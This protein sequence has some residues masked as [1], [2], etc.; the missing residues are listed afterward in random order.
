MP[1]LELMAQISRPFQIVLVALLALAMLIVAWFM[2]LHRSSGT[3]SSGTSSPSVSASAGGSANHA[4]THASSAGGGSGRIYHG[5]APGVEGLTRDIKR[6]HEAAAQE[7]RGGSYDEKHA[8]QTPAATASAG[9]PA[10]AASHA[11][12]G[13]HSASTH[14][15]AAATV[16]AHPG[17]SVSHSRASATTGSHAPAHATTGSHAQAHNS[18][19]TAAAGATAALTLNHLAEAVHLKAVINLLDP[20][21][22]A[23]IA[24]ADGRYVTAM[25]SYLQSAS[26]ATV[27]AELKQ[28]KTVLLLFL[29]PHAYDDDAVAIET[30]T[31]AHKLG[32]SIAVHFAQADQVNSFGSIT[33]DIPV[34]QTPTLLIVTPKR[35]VTTLTGLT[36]HFSI[37]QAVAE[38]R[39]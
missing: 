3:E 28:G 4:I 38:A 32:H 23:K 36:D 10:S 17:A 30:V 21:L 20:A 34:Y 1:K 35:Q 2:V 29:N 12:T 19:S 18:H 24:T 37:E 33:R 39:E 13:T 31:V 5:P 25:K 26:Q 15:A 27:T 16:R 22:R 8:G 9:A 11:S 6:A 7:A 14:H